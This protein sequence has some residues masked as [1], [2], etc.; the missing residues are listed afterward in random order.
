MIEFV[1]CDDNKDFNIMLKNKIS[2]FMSKYK[3]IECKFHCYSGYGKEF[4]KIVQIGTTFKVYF[5]DIETRSI[6]GLDAARLIREKYDD[7]NSV[8]IIVTAHEEFRYEALSNRLY[9]FDFI[10]KMNNFEKNLEIDL[11]NILK[12]Y[13]R[14]SKSIIL[15]YDYSIHRIELR[16]II[17][18]EKKIDSKKCIIVT[19][20]GKRVVQSSLNDLYKQ[21]DE[22]FMKASRSL[23]VNLKNIRG[24][25]SKT[26]TIN[27]IN[28]YES[29]LV[30]RDNKKELMERVRNSS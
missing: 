1:I 10:N 28:G 6:S 8:I 18:I 20:Y 24:F 26:N 27:F 11:T 25:D 29:S 13:T 9:L 19:S 16:D 12:Q 5:L 30:S 15:E 7:W 22:N 23:I 17:Y 2:Q 21:L 4:E 3:E 14:S